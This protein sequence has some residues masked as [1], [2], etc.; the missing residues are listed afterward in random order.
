MLGQ[1]HEGVTLL[2]QLLKVWPEVLGVT[3]RGHQTSTTLEHQKGC[4]SLAP[5]REARCFWK[6]APLDPLRAD[7]GSTRTFPA[8]V[9]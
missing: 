4:F 8:T 2:D 3:Y 6:G 5:G 1:S 7:Q 9:L